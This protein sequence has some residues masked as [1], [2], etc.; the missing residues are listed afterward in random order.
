VPIR[1]ARFASELPESERTPIEV[2]RTDT[3]LFTR[4]VES[5]RNRRD[6]WYIRPAAHIDVCNVTIPVRDVAP[7][8]R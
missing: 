2:L 5:R 1:S 6:D 7:V 8:A 3:P 4:Y